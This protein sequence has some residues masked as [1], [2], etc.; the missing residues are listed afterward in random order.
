MKAIKQPSSQ[1]LSAGTYALIAA[2]GLL[3]S[4]AFTFFFIF[5]VPRLIESGA[6]DR[7]FYLL[8]IPWALVSSTFL[9]GAMRSYARSA[10]HKLGSSIE[11]GGPVVLFA[12]IIVG[13]FRLIPQSSN[14]FDLTVRAHAADGSIP[15]VT[16]GSVTIEFGS[17]T[18]SEKIG[19]NGEANF[20]RI[21]SHFKGLTV[22][23]LA[24]VPGF[25]NEWQEH[26]LTGDALD[27]QLVRTPVPESK[28]SGTINPAPRPGDHIVIYVDGQATGISP[29]G[30]GRFTAGVNAGGG[31]RVHF[32]VYHNG[33]LVYD[34]FQTLP[35]PVTLQLNSGSV[36]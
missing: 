22:N 16:E 32:T 25:R 29:D 8:L 15:L 9:F 14:S 36:R 4:L 26:Q 17:A 12:L 20:K 6:Q 28:L 7:V 5:S 10:S 31:D 19:P 35:G 34:D 1:P 27:L 11:L 33:R 21:S 3:F 24:S 23:V 30:L 13:G 18:P 2:V